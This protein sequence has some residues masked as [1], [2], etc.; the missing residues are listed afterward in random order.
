MLTH[1]HTLT[2]CPSWLITQRKGVDEQCY[3]AYITQLIDLLKAGLQEGL[4][5][6]TEGVN[7]KKK[8]HQ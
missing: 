6:S 4:E 3:S 5:G 1:T 7:R 2:E 8:G